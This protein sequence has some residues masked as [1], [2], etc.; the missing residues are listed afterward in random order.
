[1]II[2]KNGHRRTSKPAKENPLKFEILGVDWIEDN[3]TLTKYHKYLKEV[4]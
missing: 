4:E 2:D 1:M 3:E